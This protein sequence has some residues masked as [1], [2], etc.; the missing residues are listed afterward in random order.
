MQPPPVALFSVLLSR[1]GRAA[2]IVGDLHSGVFFDPKWKWAHKW[3]L[4]VLRKRGFAIVPNGD[5][6]DICRTFDTPVVVCHGRI[7]PTEHDHEQCATAILP[8]RSFV[9]V[10]LSYSR[11]EPIEQILLAASQAPDI[12]WVFT[13]KPPAEVRA[14]APSNVSF[15][16]F[17]SNAEYRTLRIHAS[18]VLALTTQES[19]MQSAGY[20]A[21]ASATPLVTSPTGVLRDY[22]K[23][24]A[25]YTVPTGTRI[26]EAVNDTTGRPE[27]WQAAMKG[28]RDA[29]IE[30]Q[31]EAKQQVLTLL[32]Q[33][34]N[35]GKTR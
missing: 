6:A 25:R 23:D 7:T 17:V 31:G 29:I 2:V 32:L 16:G 24:A 5:L 12:E 11:D 34:Q 9:L 1:Y 3:I 21:T 10:P 19:T 22:F 35:Q 26:A 30:R 20:E 14:Q 18:T 28:H 4:R 8:K 15:P 13:G 27:F 33:H